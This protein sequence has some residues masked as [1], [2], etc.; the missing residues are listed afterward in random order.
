MFRKGH[1]LFSSASIGLIV[2][3]FMH[4]IGQFSASPDDLVFAALV[5]SMESY[6]FDLGAGKPSM[7][8]I[9]ES[10]GLT[11][12]VMLVWMG[13][14]NLLIARYTELRGKLMRRVCTLNLIGG[15][16]LVGLFVYYDVLPPAI[17][18][19]IVWVLFF[20]ARYR[21]R[22]GR[23]IHPVHPVHPLP[24]EHTAHPLP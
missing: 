20:I 13:L 19:G 10:L 1:R 5:L 22:S 12:S 18:L 24:P 16:V 7:M 11:M 17:A 14:A 23:I 8:D 9:F 6:R 15:A 2:V 4:A 3:A 21:L